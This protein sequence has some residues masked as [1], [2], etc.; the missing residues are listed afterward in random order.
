MSTGASFQ[1][2]STVMFGCNKPGYGPDPA[3]G[4]TCIYNESTGQMEWDSPLPTCIGSYLVKISLFP[5]I[6]VRGGKRIAKACTCL[7]CLH[8]KT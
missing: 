8:D 5:T 4:I 7:F 3:D 1:E 6:S 2:G